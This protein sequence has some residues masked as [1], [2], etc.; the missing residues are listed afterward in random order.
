MGI[1]LVFICKSR[2]LC[3]NNLYTLLVHRTSEILVLQEDFRKPFGCVSKFRVLLL[4]VQKSGVH[5]LRLVVFPIFIGFHTS[6][7]V[8]WDFSHQQYKGNDF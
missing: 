3:P 4:M 1:P 6:Q 7:V 8:V 2:M 5:Q